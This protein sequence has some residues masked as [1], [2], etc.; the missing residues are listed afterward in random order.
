MEEIDEILTKWGEDNIAEAIALLSS[1]NVTTSGETANALRFEVAKDAGIV[2][3]ILESEHG[4]YL[5]K[6]VK[7]A[8]D[9][10]KAPNSPFSYKD[11]MPPRGPLDKWSVKKGLAGV[12]DSKG[13]FI[14]RKS[15]VILLQRKIYRFGFAPFN[16]LAP[17][18]KNI[19]NL[20]GKILE[21][22]KREILRE[23]NKIT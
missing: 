12:R 16:Y 9:S 20:N 22:Q 17:F 18:F 23:L 5:R 21:S 3:R 14:P 19:D 8:V 4:V 10:S 11:K 6:G 1:S 13:R 15:L 2:L 7:G